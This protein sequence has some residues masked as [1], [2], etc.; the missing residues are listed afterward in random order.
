M[1]VDWIAGLAMRDYVQRYFEQVPARIELRLSLNRLGGRRFFRA[2]GRELD[3][4]LTLHGATLTLS[5]E[6]LTAREMV[7]VER[8]LAR[9]ARHGDRI[10]IVVGEQLRESLRVDSSRFN[11]VLRRA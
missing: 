5:I 2:L 6:Q 10:F 11:L 7:R 8:L 1:I 4:L 9:L 3:R